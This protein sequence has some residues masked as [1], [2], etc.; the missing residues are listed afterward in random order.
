MIGM[1][2][3]LGILDDCFQIVFKKMVQDEIFHEVESRSR[4]KEVGSPKLG[5]IT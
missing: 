5:S 4:R 1:E 2:M 3:D